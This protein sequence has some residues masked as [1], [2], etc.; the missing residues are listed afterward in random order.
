L[1]EKIRL[2]NQTNRT[3]VIVLGLLYFR[4]LKY[5]DRYHP[6]YEQTLMSDYI[7]DF[8]LSRTCE[9]KEQRKKEDEESNKISIT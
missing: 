1:A 4:C 7:M 3:I 5:G 2:I 9:K 8:T 6:S